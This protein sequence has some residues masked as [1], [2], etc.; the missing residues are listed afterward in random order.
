[1]GVTLPPLET[2]QETRSHA[3]AE[4]IKARIG[5]Q[6]VFDYLGIEQ[7]RNRRFPC[8]WTDHSRD[9]TEPAVSIL[10]DGQRAHCHK[11][12]NSGDIFEILMVATG[13]NFSEALVTLSHLSGVDVAAPTPAEIEIYRNRKR[14]KRIASARREAGII[15]DIATA[16]PELPDAPEAVKKVLDELNEA[17]ATGKGKKTFPVPDA[18][19]EAPNKT[20]HD[21]QTCPVG[22]DFDGEAPLNPDLQ[23][24]KRVRDG[25]FGIVPED[26]RMD[27]Q[28]FLERFTEARRIISEETRRHD[29]KI[30]YFGKQAKLSL[31]A[32]KGLRERQREWRKSLRLHQRRIRWETGVLAN[33]AADAGV[34]VMM[35]VKEINEA[36]GGWSRRH[37]RRFRLMARRE[38]EFVAGFASD[39]AVLRAI[40]L[41]LLGEEERAIEEAKMEE[42]KRERDERAEVLG[43]LK[44][45]PTSKL[46]FALEVI[47]NAY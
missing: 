34:P 26:G 16:R 37:I 5:V 24:E 29:Y 41:E 18:P 35:F 9:A 38:W 44:K 36:D 45:L 14:E 1:M 8:V 23:L 11:C 28:V 21:S 10:P 47:E 19:E 15:R 30:A 2:P 40:E 46:R 42:E 17:L 6:G 7:G 25:G 13:A 27:T 22:H 3:P 32:V 31:M 43:A 12:G 39:K 33:L 20:G 4:R